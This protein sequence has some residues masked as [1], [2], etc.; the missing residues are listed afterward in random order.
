MAQLAALAV[1]LRSLAKKTV[2]YPLWIAL[3]LMFPV[4]SSAALAPPPGYSASQLVFDDQF[5]LPALDS[6]KWIPQIA[7]A[8]G[9]WRQSVPPPYSAPNS[10]SFSVQYFDPFPQ[11]GTN[12]TGPHVVTGNGL[13]LIATPS[14]MFKGYTWASGVVCTHG[15]FYFTGGY[16]QVRAKMPDARTGMW[17]ALWLLEGG[18]EIDLQESGFR[19]GSS[20]VNH[21]MAMNFHATGGIQH[22]LDTGIDLSA[23]YHVYGVEYKP[24]QSLRIYL[25]NVLMATY[26]QNIPTGA[27]E[28]LM[29]LEVAGSLA[30]G[31]HTVASPNTSN[32]GEFDVSEVQVYHLP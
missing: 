19:L 11:Q 9:I 24:G 3:A 23:D 14:R 18:G 22:L 32:P 28:I 25:D 10:G 2:V 8:S 15:L 21:V 17:A 5:L 26:R 31:W 16:L 6:T 1:F 27:Y 30:T 29:D 12:Q 7:D 4:L 20:N 13:R